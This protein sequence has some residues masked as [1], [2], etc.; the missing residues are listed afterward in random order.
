[1]LIV[2]HG[3]KEM[4]K[5]FEKITEMFVAELEKEQLPWRREWSVGNPGFIPHNAVTGRHYRGINVFVL[6]MKQAI[7]GYTSTGWIT[8]TEMKKRGLN[9]KGEKPTWIVFWNP[10]TR[11]KIDNNGDEVEE[12]YLNHFMYK[13]WNLDQ[14]TGDKSKLKGEGEIERIQIDSENDV[15]SAIREGLNVGFE[16]YG[17]RAFYSP[18]HDKIVM[19]PRDAFATFDAYC[20][21]S[22]HE[23]IHATGH[24]DRLNRDLKNMYGTE[25]YAF[26]EL[27]AELG[28]CYLQSVLGISMNVPNHISYLKSWIKILKDDS[29]NIVRAASRAQ[30]AVDYFLENVDLENSEDLELAA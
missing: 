26:E 8:T 28:S 5:G 19:P 22:F 29:R 7:H 15:C 13:V 20:S 27:I 21:T 11:T 18:T 25:A 23:G 1:M 14:V 17:D 24:K 6:M 30:K 9:W 2:Q 3:N 16:H 10:R 12:T 4:S